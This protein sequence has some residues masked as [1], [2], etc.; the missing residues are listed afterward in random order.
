VK[1]TVAKVILIINGANVSVLMKN[2]ELNDKLEKGDKRRAGRLLSTFLREIAQEEIS[3]ANGDTPP[4][5][6]TKARALADQI[7][8]RA[9]GRFTYREINGMIKT[10]PPDKQ[11]IELIFERCEGRVGTEEEEKKKD[12]NVPDRVSDA[13]KQK[14][15]KIAQGA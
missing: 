3:V 13:N 7:W 4:R 8:A 5:K 14:L 11:M 6:V 1:V 15:I 9:L 12:T 10:P 2:Q